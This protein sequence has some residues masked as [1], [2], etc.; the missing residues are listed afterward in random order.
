MGDQLQLPSTDEERRAVFG[1]VLA[2]KTFARSPR[3]VSLLRYLGE[4][5]PNAL[6][7][8]QIGIHVFGRPE[9]YNPMEDNIVRSSARLLRQKLEEYY[10]SEG[11]ADTLRVAI[12]RGR[13]VP[14]IAL[15]AVQ[16]P[17][18]NLPPSD[19][20]ALTPRRTWLRWVVG[21][22]LA[23]GAAALINSSQ[24]GADPLGRFWRKLLDPK[25]RTFVVLSDTAYVLAQDA[26]EQAIPLE[27]YFNSERWNHWAGLA[28][29]RSGIP[30]LGYRRYTGVVDAEFALRV[31]RRPEAKDVEV[32]VR[33][34]RDLSIQDARGAN[35][36]VLG[37]PHA[38]PW[39][40]LL[41]RSANFRIHLRFGDHK[42]HV[43]N[44]RPIAS[45]PPQ[46][47]ADE[48]RRVY[49]VAS[50]LPR[51]DGDGHA[52]LLGGAT[53]AGTETAKDLVLNPTRF[54]AF[55][56]TIGAASGSIPH[57]ESVWQTTSLAGN[58]PA[59]ELIASRVLT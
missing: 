1:R 20:P 44:R 11:A 8:H 56:Q 31:A 7:E 37:A 10:K 38:N 28:G 29:K 16:P 52:L 3:L 49:G 33:F 2:S 59:A 14:E 9:S 36:L 24:Q 46:W 54:A 4:A 6:N 39:I 43:L 47:E 55:L 12:P 50:F 40:S 26:L 5:S 19:P 34:A 27:D 18:I 45:E 42:F 41:D 57:F 23:A 53:I 25:R 51:T 48:L 32:L 22:S 30:T 35:L 58:A 15:H 17:P 21:G 13:Y